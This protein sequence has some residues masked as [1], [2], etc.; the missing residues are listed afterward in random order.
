MAEFLLAIGLLGTAFAINGLNSQFAKLQ[1]R[2]GAVEV[3]LTGTAKRAEDAELMS[4][5]NRDR[6]EALRFSNVGG[7]R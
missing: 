6:L 5:N 7:R 2:V 1:A 3:R 4:S